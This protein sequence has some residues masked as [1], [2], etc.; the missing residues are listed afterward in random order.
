MPQKSS[1][2]LT[3]ILLQAFVLYMFVYREKELL[4]AY[5]E[6]LKQLKLVKRTFVQLISGDF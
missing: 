5:E 4:R 2:N 3:A 1:L 6:T